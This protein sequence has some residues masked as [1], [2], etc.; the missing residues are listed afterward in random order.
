M[1]YAKLRGRRISSGHRIRMAAPRAVRNGRT[2]LWTTCRFAGSGTIRSFKTACEA[3]RREMRLKPSQGRGHHTMGTAEA[4][5]SAF[6]SPSPFIK[7]LELTTEILRHRVSGQ[8]TARAL[9]CNGHSQRS[10]CLGSTTP[11]HFQDQPFPILAN[12]DDEVFTV[13][14]GLKH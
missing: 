5:G 6:P 9:R 13:P 1:W 2:W 7:Y 11:R 14:E 10:L 8:S 3:D 12:G 4:H